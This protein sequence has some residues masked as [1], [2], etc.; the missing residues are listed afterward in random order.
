M[1]AVSP[2][3]NGSTASAGLSGS[4]PKASRVTLELSP[5]GVLFAGA[6]LAVF[7]LAF[8]LAAPA[9]ALLG[10]IM[11]AGIVAARAHHAPAGVRLEPRIPRHAGL[12][13]PVRIVMRATS[14]AEGLLS[15]DT[16]VPAT[17]EMVER[18]APAGRQQA[19]ER[20]L[21]VP[22]TT[23]TIT[24]K[25]TTVHAMDRWGLWSSRTRFPLTDRMH[26][27]PEPHWVRA[28]QKAGRE[29]P[30][31]RLVRNRYAT[32]LSV[33]VKNIREYRYGDRLRDI[34]WPRSSLGQGLFVREREQV[35]PRPV[36]VLLDA[37]QSMRWT[38][39]HSKLKTATRIAASVLTA[40]NTA[41][42]RTSLVSFDEIR[43]HDHS[44]SPGYT[45]IRDALERLA[46]L[47]DAAPP[48]PVPT[49]PVHLQTRDPPVPVAPATTQVPQRAKET[50]RSRSALRGSPV[51][52]ALGQVN[53]ILAGPGLVVAVLD[54]EIDAS[55]C[56][57]IVERLRRSGHEVVLVI[58]A[59]GPHHYLRHEA[60]KSVLARL[61]ALQ[62]ARARV[63]EEAGKMQVSV[64]VAYPGGEEAIVREVGGRFR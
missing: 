22:G 11:T 12:T 37:R 3:T 26:V 55:R 57:R 16:Q 5:F 4:R 29:N 35:T 58:P 46:R 6:V 52:A 32:E 7:L 10:L 51:A 28:G 42:V 19:Q 1:P 24:W 49:P 56:I 41:G 25:E 23:G 30:I 33:E 44:Q 40:A 64:L 45:S 9:L 39:R 62:Q 59:T 43:L 63:E 15:V 8:L 27:S 13:M 53:R 38:R 36:L 47:P 60:K 50:G 31:T 20:L 17:M 48:Q 2:A 14:D 61:R 34:D 54:A 18:V 21:V